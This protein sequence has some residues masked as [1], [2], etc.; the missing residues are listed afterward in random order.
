MMELSAEDA[1]LLWDDVV[2]MARDCPDPAVVPWLERLD[3]VSFEGDVMTL[4][5][6]QNWTAKKTMGDYRETIESLLSEITMERV[7]LNVVVAGQAPAAPAQR[8][9]LAADGAPASPAAPS[10]PDAPAVPEAAQAER[11]GGEP[12]AAAAPEAHA[13]GHVSAAALAGA[14]VAAGRGMASLPRRRTVLSSLG[15]APEPPEARREPPAARP[16]ATWPAPQPPA[17]LPAQAAQASQA[18]VAAGPSGEPT[19]GA[20]IQAQP[21]AAAPA[22]LPADEPY[23]GDQESDL[24]FD[25]YIVGESNKLAYN[26]ARAVAEQPGTLSNLNPLFIWGPS[27]NGKTHLLRSIENYLSEHQPRMHV[28]FVNANEFVENYIDDIRNKRLR[29]TEV[30]KAY[31]SVDVLLVDDVQFFESKQESVSTFFDIFNQLKDHGRQI[32][33]AA[34]TPPDYLTLDDRM[35][36]RFGSG[37]VVDIKAPTYEMKRSILKSYY[38]RYRS[39]MEWCEVEIPP[40]VLDLMAQLA[41]SNPR[42]MQGLMTSVL[43]KAND[44]PAILSPEGIKAAVNDLFKSVQAVSVPSIIRVVCEEYGVRE[45]D[46]KGASRKKN[47]SEARQVVMW[48]ARSLTDSSYEEIGKSV[49]NRD[50]STVYYGISTIEKRALEDKGYLYKLERLKEEVT[51]AR[52]TA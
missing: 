28:L 49:G 26:M 11:P 30:L 42:T 47:I 31:R 14:A 22:Q 15:G 48:M 13:P 38:D 21:P 12:G 36:T 51:G 45:E 8:Q 10:A 24:R 6:R 39:R 17:P 9:A 43:I 27:G 35:R 52:G 37:L 32:V 16:D 34:D 2:E 4:S 40:K 50:H 29:G 7:S 19:P 1:R 5:T 20:P 18:P 41:P 44:N 23:I 3:P 25:T 46:I 33:L